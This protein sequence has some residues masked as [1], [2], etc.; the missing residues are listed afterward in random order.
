MDKICSV[1][2]FLVLFVGCYGN[3]TDACPS[4]CACGSKKSDGQYYADCNGKGLKSFPALP[5][6]TRLLYLDDNEL[7]YI[8]RD[9]LKRMTNLKHLDISSNRYTT[10]PDDAFDDLSSLEYLG[11]GSV[12]LRT[13]PSAAFRNLTNLEELQVTHSSIVDIP[14]GAFRTL[15]KMKR[16]SLTS[17]T[18]THLQLKEGAFAGMDNLEYIG[19]YG[20]NITDLPDDIF[21]GKIKL[22]RIFLQGNLL[23]SLPDSI[24]HLMNLKQ[25]SVHDNPLLKCTCHLSEQLNKLKNQNTDLQIDGTC[26]KKRYLDSFQCED[27]GRARDTIRPKIEDRDHDDDDKHDRDH[28]SNMYLNNTKSASSS[29]LVVS[30][31]FAIVSFSVM[32]LKV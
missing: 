10:I 21:M 6:Q 16:I 3:P 17:N 11:L 26:D 9:F 15:K 22:K 14:E 32:I 12:G 2:P 5:S 24:V 20:N 27:E 30:I 8:K 29:L 1:L 25:L 31:S 18:H 7:T 13:I 23:E 19:L 28:A 4:V